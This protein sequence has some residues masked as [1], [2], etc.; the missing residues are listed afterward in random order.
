LHADKLDIYGGI[1][2]GSGFAFHPGYTDVNG[3]RHS[4]VDA[5]L[6][7]GVQAGARYYFK[8]GIGVFGEVGWGKTWLNAGITWKV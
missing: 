4:A 5:L 3:A 1:N 8:P 6:F 2:L 7:G